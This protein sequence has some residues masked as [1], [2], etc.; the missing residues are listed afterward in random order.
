MSNN[1]PV[2]SG[3]IGPFWPE[4]IIP[5]KFFASDFDSAL[6]AKIESY[7]NQ[8]SISLQ[9]EQRKCIEFVKRENESDYIL[10]MDNG[11]CSSEIGF[12]NGVNRIS[13]NKKCISSRNIIHQ[14]MHR[15]GFDHEHSRPDRDDFIDIHIHNTTEANDNRNKMNYII[16]PNLSKETIEQSPYD[17]HS[18]L[19]SSSENVIVSS[20]I[21][22]FATADNFNTER[23]QM[24]PIDI[25]QIQT[26]YSCKLLKK[27]DII[28]EY[29][30]EDSELR[31]RI[32]KRFHIE[33]AYVKKTH[34]LISNYLNRT[35]ET[36]GMNHYWTLE[37]PIVQSQHKDYLF[38]CKEKKK[39]FEKCSFSIE[40][41]PQDKRVC[42]RPFFMK[43]G[44][45]SSLGSSLGRK[46][47]DQFFK[48]IKKV[49]D[50]IG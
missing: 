23:N 46:I 1:K 42:V 28:H 35:F 44:F 10:F 11:D 39:S 34:D 45:C 48:Q 31:S 50:I 20:K 2:I 22:S 40:C 18:I 43:T 9:V 32:E 17:Y 26:S 16:N 3:T 33:A 41:G 25:L 14:L 5:Y 15:L 24:S 36:C 12:V 7:L 19:H 27:P 8:F 29:D 4:S 49:K 6:K 30:V 38:Y 47:N 37:Y 21:E 13:L